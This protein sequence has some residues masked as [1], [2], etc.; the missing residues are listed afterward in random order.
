MYKY[1]VSYDLNKNDKDYDGLIDA[2]K[3]YPNIKALYSTW[4]VKSNDSATTIYNHLKPYIDNN[5]H[6]FVIE[7]VTSNEQGWMPKKVW[8]WLDN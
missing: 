5:D 7:V 3:D 2:I 8:D 4:F 1:C 6:L